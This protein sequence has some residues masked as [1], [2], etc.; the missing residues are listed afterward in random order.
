MLLS[1]SLGVGRLGVGG[2]RGG[3]SRGKVPA[4]GVSVIGG[5]CSGV[6]YC[7]CGG[8]G[9]GGGRC[10]AWSILSAVAAAVWWSVIEAGC[11][12]GASDIRVS[13]MVASWDD[14]GVKDGAV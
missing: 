9:G 8:G 2:S 6:G 10:W 7:C 4:G 3:C 5:A 12:K 14:G 1:Y 11:M 13:V